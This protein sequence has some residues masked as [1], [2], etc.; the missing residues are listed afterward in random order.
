MRPI[1]LGNLIKEYLD[2]KKIAKS[3]LARKLNK[4]DATI[5]YYQKQPS[6]QVHILQN[7]CHALQHNFFQDIAAQL[8]TSYSTSVPINHTKDDIIAQLQQ[9]III[10]KAEKEVLLQAFKK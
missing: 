10:L 2:G 5:L 4:T 1:H 3:A 8:P 9:E 7:L 6:L